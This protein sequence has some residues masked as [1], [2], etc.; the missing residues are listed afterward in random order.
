MLDRFNFFDVYAYLLPGAVAIALAW[1]P[2]VLLGAD[3]P[4]GAVSG[5]LALLGGRPCPPDPCQ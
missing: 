3:L 4:S 1:L 5:A 2:Y